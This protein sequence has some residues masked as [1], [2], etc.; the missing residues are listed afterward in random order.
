[1]KIGAFANAV[2]MSIMTIR[3]YMEEKLLHPQKHGS[4]WDFSEQDLSDMAYIQKMR[5]CGFSIKTMR[6]LMELRR[7]G[8]SDPFR[9]KRILEEEYTRLLAEQRS[10]AAALELLKT[11]VTSIDAPPENVRCGS[12]PFSLLKL[13]ACPY[14]GCGLD[15]ENAVIRENALCSGHGFCKCGFTADIEDGILIA[16]NREDTLIRIVDSDRQTLKKRRPQDVSCIEKYYVWLLEQLKEQDLND[17]VIFE[18]VIN[19]ICFCS[20]AVTELPGNPAF[21]LCDTDIRVVRYYARNMRLLKPDCKLLM[22]VDDG[23]HHPLKKNCIDIVL[24]YCSSE[25]HQAYGYPSIATVIA[26]YVRENAFLLGRFSRMTRRK[27]PLALTKPDHGYG[28][29]IRY[30]LDVFLKDLKEHNILL[31]SEIRGEEQLDE[32]IYEGCAPGDEIHPYVFTGCWK[33]MPEK[34]TEE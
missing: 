22:I 20:R 18:D 10:L 30:N 17:R 12:I 33:G 32:S 29:E 16:H 26:P 27:L 6:Q 1:M 13:I 19:A 11:A 24:D 2:D 15:W 28:D 7:N 14:C 3:F 4:L 8:I 9:K 34:N 23:V 31:L 21:I 5:S 25:I